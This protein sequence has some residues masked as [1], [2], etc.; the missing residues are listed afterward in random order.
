VASDPT[1]VD[2]LEEIRAALDG[3]EPILLGR[4]VDIEMS[5][6]R[7][8]ADP[9]L[10]RR[11]FA[12]FIK[13]AVARSDAPDPIT[14]RVA[15]TGKVVRIEVINEGGPVV[16]DDLPDLGSAREELRAMGGELGTPEPGG[17][18]AGWM[19]VALT[20]GAASAADA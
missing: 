5:R 15:R 8:L 7:V 2:L 10:F 19:S 14:V 4:T 20:S 16:R 6:L 13:F 11:V 1:S 9:V 18:V 17:A 3:L 12:E